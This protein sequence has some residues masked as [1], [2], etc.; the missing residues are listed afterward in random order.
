[1]DSLGNN[2]NIG[3]CFIFQATLEVCLQP[4]ITTDRNK[5]KIMYISCNK[6]ELSFK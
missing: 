3:L 4:V 6:W 5:A 1:M 2:V